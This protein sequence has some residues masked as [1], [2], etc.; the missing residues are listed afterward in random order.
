MYHICFR[1][2]TFSLVEVKCCQLETN[3]PGGDYDHNFSNKTVFPTAKTTFSITKIHILLIDNVLF[4]IE[5]VVLGDG[6]HSSDINQFV[7]GHRL[8]GVRNI[9]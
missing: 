7:D 6:K 9:L 1:S 4:E 3:L 5:K 8:P 2:E